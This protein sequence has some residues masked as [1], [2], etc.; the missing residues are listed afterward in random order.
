MSVALK[1]RLLYLER[2]MCGIFGAVARQPVT[3]IY[4]D[5]TEFDHPRNL[6]KRVTVE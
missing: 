6:T 3:G 5:E 1:F 2:G 4:K